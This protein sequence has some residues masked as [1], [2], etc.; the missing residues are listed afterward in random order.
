MAGQIKEIQFKIEDNAN[1]N[2]LMGQRGTLHTTATIEQI[3]KEHKSYAI[4]YEFQWEP[5][6]TEE[7]S[8]VDEEREQDLIV[9]LAQMALSGEK[10]FALGEGTVH[11]PLEDAQYLLF[12]SHDGGGHT[13]VICKD[14]DEVMSNLDGII[15]IEDN[16]E[17]FDLQEV[18]NAVAKLKIR[19]DDWFELPSSTWFTITKVASAPVAQPS[20]EYIA[21]EPIE[22]EAF[23]VFSTDQWQSNTSYELEGACS[24]IDQAREV[25]AKIFK[26]Y[27]EDTKAVIK[28]TLLD[29]NDFSDYEV[30]EYASGLEW[31]CDESE[32]EYGYLAQTSEEE[33][34]DD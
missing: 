1:I 22:T 24:T 30:Y 3:D 4:N 11:H 13:N 18:S 25:V 20:I 23:L 19:S 26:E 28:H 21:T 7:K 14:I 17:E 32:A 8:D 29:E 10:L 34:E 9:A 6:F 16:E 5:S 15:E 2:I 27:G 12:V 33:G 31:K